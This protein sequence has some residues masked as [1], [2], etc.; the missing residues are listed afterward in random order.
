MNCVVLVDLIYWSDQYIYCAFL[1][2]CLMF[3]I[4]IMVQTAIIFLRFWFI[5]LTNLVFLPQDDLTN[6][7]F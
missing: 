5:G 4:T 2:T 1:L 7:R 3:E 6:S